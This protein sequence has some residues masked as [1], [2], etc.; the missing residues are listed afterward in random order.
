MLGCRW[1]YSISVYIQISS[2]DD[3][4][5]WLN[6][7]VVKGM[8]ATH[9]YNDEPIDPGFTQDMYSNLFGGS[10]LRQLRIKDRKFVSLKS[11]SH[12]PKKLFYFLQWKLMKNAFYFIIEAFFVLKILKFLCWFFGHVETTAWFERQGQF[13]NLWRHSFTAWLTSSC[14]THIAQYLRSKGNRVMTFS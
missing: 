6:T 2:L 10:R 5:T 3:V 12:L 4:W 14:N 1:T 8:Y 13:Q 7:T 9:Y 11:N